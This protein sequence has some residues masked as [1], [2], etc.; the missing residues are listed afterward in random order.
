MAIRLLGESTCLFRVHLISGRARGRFS[1]V[2]QGKA[3]FRVFPVGAEFKR[4]L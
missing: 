4:W 1:D 3:E 2:Y